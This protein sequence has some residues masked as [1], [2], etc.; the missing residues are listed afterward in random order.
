M[1][2]V[3]SPGIGPWAILSRP[4]FSNTPIDHARTLCEIEKPREGG[5]RG[6]GGLPVNTITEGPVILAG[7]KSMN[8]LPAEI[9]TEALSNI[10]SPRTRIHE[11][12]FNNTKSK[13]SR[14]S[15]GIIIQHSSSTKYI[16]SK[17]EDIKFAKIFYLKQSIGKIFDSLH[18]SCWN[19]FT[20]LYPHTELKKE[21]KKR[22]IFI[23]HLFIFPG[24]V[25][26]TVGR[27][28]SQL[29]VDI[30]RH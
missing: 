28:R 27:T 17:N 20:L 30:P 8:W 15:L 1:P 16:V 22:N 23:K 14:R 29:Q 26:R 13:S 9:V 7:K 11:I 4:R 12:F 25:S 3:N 19:F 21:K 6:R 2:S 18:L 24:K 5:T 10:S